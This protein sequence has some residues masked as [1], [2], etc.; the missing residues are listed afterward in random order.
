MAGYKLT[1]EIIDLSEAVVWDLAKLEWG[2]AEVYEADEPERC[3]C[4]H[5]PIKE[6]CVLLNQ[7]NG[8]RTEV[9]N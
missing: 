9:G 8:N 5:F 4:G 7:R 2:L 1:N 6:V 3:L